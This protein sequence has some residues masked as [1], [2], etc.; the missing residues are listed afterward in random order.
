RRLPL[1]HL[2]RRLQLRRLPRLLVFIVP[3]SPGRRSQGCARR[4]ALA[5][6][7]VTARS[8]RREL[9]CRNPAAFVRNQ[10]RAA[11]EGFAMKRTTRS[12]EP[13]DPPAQTEATP[14]VR[15]AWE[16]SYRTKLLAGV[17]GLVLLTGV[18]VTWLAH[19]SARASTE[20][21]TDARFRE[22]S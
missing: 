13:E 18:T 2:R 8:I 11:G 5:A 16:P 15:S 4:G 9:L 10:R 14:P 21:M 12:T 22:V 6:T 3:N 20:A 7:A 19:R 1:R 17:C